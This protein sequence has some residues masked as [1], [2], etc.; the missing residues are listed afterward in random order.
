[1]ASPQLP[2]ATQTE[3]MVVVAH[4]KAMVAHTAYVT[5]ILA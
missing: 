5:V 1:M 4:S 3:V 2:L